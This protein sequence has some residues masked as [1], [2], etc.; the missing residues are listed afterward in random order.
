[1]KKCPTCMT[2]DNDA[3]RFC[4]NCGAELFSEERFNDK[5]EKNEAPK[6][7]AKYVDTRKLCVLAMMCALAFILAAYV[8]IPIVSAVSFLRYDP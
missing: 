7:V 4:N 5:S 2:N 6:Q 3:Q 1:M 8:R